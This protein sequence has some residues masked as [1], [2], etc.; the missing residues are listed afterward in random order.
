MNLRSSYLASCSLSL[1]AAACGADDYQAPAE[2][3][4]ALPRE[5]NPAVAPAQL[6]EIVAG[7]T[8]FAADLY[9]RVRTE[10]GNLF[11]SPYS[12]SLALAMTYAGAN[13]TTASQM[14]DTLHFTLPPA[15][16][17]AAWNALDLELASRAAAAS[18][19]ERPFRLS[20]ANSIWGQQGKAFEAP[21]L[22][23]LAV[24]YGAGL[25]VLDF[26]ANPEAARGTINAW[27]EQQT[28]DKIVDLLP[29]GSITDLTKLVLTN[30]IY[31]SAAW[32]EPFEAANTAD[33][34]FT[35]AGGS[36]IQVPTLSQNALNAYAAGADY[37]AAQL[38]YDGEQLGMLVI[39]PTGD[40][41][42]FEASLDATKLAAITASL[43]E[44]QLDLQLPKFRF[45]APL[46]LADT[47]Q[48]MGMTDA[49]TG[50]ADFSG[51]DG[52][53]DLAISDVVH[54][55][56]VGI[57]E[58]GTEAAAAT[59]VIIGDT[60]APEPA[61]LHADRPFIFAIRDLPTGAILFV[62]RVV[63]PR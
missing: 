3:R 46:G 25:H 9:G 12:I 53:R 26:Q 50:A 11:M 44:A 54:K 5:L 43:H 62:G 31:F 51:I 14:A 35:L 38:A 20:I 34:A 59:A 37:A 32:N 15:E 42:A 60:S 4:S 56:F 41:G 8:A 6:D 36:T 58:A 1:L 21:F 22:D 13:G 29:A 63:D 49:F 2:V 28:N 61:T 24:N 27:V 39:V 55:G 7:N 17:H 16:L 40:F 57:D 52:T 10:S 19:T 45:D 30:A 23:T 33:R 47:L 18:S 48:A